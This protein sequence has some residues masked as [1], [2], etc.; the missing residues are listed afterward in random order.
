LCLSI[1]VNVYLGVLAR[2]FYIRYRQL[3]QEIRNAPAVDGA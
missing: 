3:A 1:A 2:G